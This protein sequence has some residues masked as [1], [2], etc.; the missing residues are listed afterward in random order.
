MAVALMDAGDRFRR[1]DGHDDLTRLRKASEEEI[2]N[3]NLNEKKVLFLTLFQL[4][5]HSCH[6]GGDLPNDRRHL[7]H[8]RMVRR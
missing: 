7:F 6:T 1:L 5:L 2:P 8:E 3:E 4:S